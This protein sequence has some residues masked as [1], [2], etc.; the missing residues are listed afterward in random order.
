MAR[1]RV[2]L[3]PAVWFVDLEIFP[4]AGGGCQRREDTTG[5]RWLQVCCLPFFGHAAMPVLLQTLQES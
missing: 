4:V 1:S 5:P 3:G 2:L